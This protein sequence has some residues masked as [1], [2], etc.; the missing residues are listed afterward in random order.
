MNSQ[1]SGASDASFP[2]STSPKV[3]S[4][5]PLR[6]ATAVRLLVVVLR[7]HSIRYSGQGLRPADRSTPGVCGRACPGRQWNYRHRMNGWRRRGAVVRIQ[8]SSPVRLETD[9]RY[10]HLTASLCCAA[11]FAAFR[12]IS[13]KPFSFARLAT[14]S[15]DDWPVSRLTFSS[16]SAR[17]N[18][19]SN[20]G[21]K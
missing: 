13:K 8:P 6:H 7:G 1:N 15:S 10:D 2:P 20:S 17:A 5:W 21:P 3:L 19:I 12:A 4:A 14:A 18:R 16:V 11:A 9:S